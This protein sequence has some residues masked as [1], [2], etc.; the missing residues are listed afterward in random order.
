MSQ[1][2]LLVAA[3]IAT[4]L[5]AGTFAAFSAAVLPGL[6][7][8]SDRTFV[9]AMRQA[10]AAIQNPLFFAAFFGA[11]VLPAAAAWSL[12]GPAAGWALA[13]LA[14]Y[15]VAFAT[16]V[17]VNVPLN[18][19]LD[20]AGEDHAAARAAYERPWT[21]ANHARVVAATAALGC[22]VLAALSC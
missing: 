3:A 19:R 9:E 2:A 5:V 1:Q 11:A 17:V 13:G 10:N 22:L 6:A 20:A 16:T 14:C 8:G 7:R 18:N 15:L 12:D 4:G 21:R